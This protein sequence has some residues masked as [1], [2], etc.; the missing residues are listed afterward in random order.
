VSDWTTGVDALLS[1]EHAAVPPSR[2]RLAL[3]QP[4]LQLDLVTDDPD[5]PPLLR[6]RP[7]VPGATRGWRVSGTSWSV[8]GY[9]QQLGEQPPLPAA[10]TGTSGRPHGST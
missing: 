2:V 8:V 4:A 1:S 7:V 3:A 5:R 10:I 9:G 6:A